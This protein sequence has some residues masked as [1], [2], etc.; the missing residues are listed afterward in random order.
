MKTAINIFFFFVSVVAFSQK[1][2]E[3]NL[4]WSL[5]ELEKVKIL[6][7]SGYGADMNS[8]PVHR[9][10]KG[11]GE[12]QLVSVTTSIIESKALSREELKGVPDSWLNRIESVFEVSINYSRRNKKKDAVITYFPLIKK[13]GAIHK[14]T[15]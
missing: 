14:I 10:K 12:N 6:S 15:S 9:E 1:S 13:N 8:L 7:I 11:L 3:I 4:N 2:T 5:T